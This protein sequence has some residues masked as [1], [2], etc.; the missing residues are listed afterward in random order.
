[1]VSDSMKVLT[2]VLVVIYFIICEAIVLKTNKTNTT[3]KQ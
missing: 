2:V 1:M 3:V